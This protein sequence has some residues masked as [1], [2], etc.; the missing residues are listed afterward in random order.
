VTP[1]TGDS[2]P[3]GV[4]GNQ[5]AQLSNG[6]YLE[7][8]GI[9]F[10]SGSSQFDARVASGAAGGVSGLVNVVLD[11]P[12]NAPIGNFAIANTG[13]WS[14][15]RTIPANITQTT[16]VHNVYLEFQS[17][18]GGNPPYVSLHYFSFPPH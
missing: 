1:A 11:N 4:D 6:K 8:N 5:A 13:G 16:G 10:G 15:W 14:S 17:G 3:A 12:N 2:N 9:N 18:A 7:Y